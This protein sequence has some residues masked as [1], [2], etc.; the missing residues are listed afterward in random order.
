MPRGLARKTTTSTLK[1]LKKKKKKKKRQGIFE[2]KYSKSKKIQN[3]KKIFAMGKP[4]F[5]EINQP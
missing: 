2:E 4:L 3:R 1:E 5:Y